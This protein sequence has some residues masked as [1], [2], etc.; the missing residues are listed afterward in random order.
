[1]IFNELNEKIQAALA[2]E[3]FSIP[4][5]IQKKAIPI[6]LERKDLIGVAQTGTGKTA[7]F[8]LPILHLLSAESKAIEPN[9]PL[10]LV[11]SPTRELAM[12]IDESFDI[13]GKLLNIKHNV[14]FGGVSQESQIE[15]LSEGTHVLTATPGRL[16]DL[17]SQEK[18]NL[19]K[20]EYIVIDEAHMMLSM[21][22]LT[23]VKEIFAQ[24]P[25]KRQSLFF[26]ATMSPEILK[27]ANV[28]LNDP[29]IVESKTEFDL[30]LQKVFFLYVEDKNRLLIELL[31]TK[32]KKK[33][34]V[35]LRTKYKTEV[36]AN[37]LIKNKFSAR[38][39]HG[40]KNQK[41]RTKA[42]EDFKSGKVK[43]LVA[44]DIAARG[45][46]ID[47]VSSVIN[48]DTPNS[49]DVYVHR[50]GRTARAGKTGKSYT[51]CSL[52]ERESLRKIEEHTGQNMEIIHHTYYAAKVENANPEDISTTT[53]KKNYYKKTS[54]KNTKNS[55][56]YVPPINIKKNKKPRG[57]HLHKFSK[58]H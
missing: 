35:F 46:H 52:E 28:L 51:L 26:S 19:S 50:I 45:I 32:A 49:P 55:D 4:T 16:L 42:I 11:L 9:S 29:S 27:L 24:I 48:Y 5:D 23:P 15:A 8:V 56:E 7:S 41:E 34:I 20:V 31:K 30:I 2:K 36:V 38:A 18:V 13:F 54:K 37:L 12:Q 58:Q 22:F 44:T 57:I 3:A 1:M 17:I 14:I 47:N 40:D 53:K 39:I 10:V 33:T 25:I 43:I 6:I 21:G